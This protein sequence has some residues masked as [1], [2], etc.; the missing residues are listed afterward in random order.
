[1]RSSSPSTPERVIRWLASAAHHLA[2]QWRTPADEVETAQFMQRDYQARLLT[3][4]RL[5]CGDVGLMVSL[6]L[7]REWVRLF[8]SRQPI[9]SV[10]ATDAETAPGGMMGRRSLKPGRTRML[11]T[12]G[13]DSGC[14]REAG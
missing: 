3:Q 1:M 2:W 12:C 11:R 4:P 8:A 9:P 13:I 5:V 7:D 14:R 10:H 6:L